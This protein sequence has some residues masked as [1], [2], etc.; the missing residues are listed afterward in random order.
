MQLSI[1]K[2]QKSDNAILAAIVRDTLTEFGCNKPGTAFADPET[3]FLFEQYADSETLYLVALINNKI[4][5]GAGVGKLKN[6]NRVCELQKMYLLPEARGKGIA[7]LLLQLC[8]EFAKEKKYKSIYLESMP[9][10]NAAIKLY[11]NYGFKKLDAP[12]SQTGHFTCNVW[13]LKEL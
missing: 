9:E 4:V 11:E 7:Q 12:L 2:I 13:M 3:D 6:M 5:G 8:I 10:L 1:R